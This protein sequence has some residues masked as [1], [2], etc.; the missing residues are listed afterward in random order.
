MQEMVFT[1]NFNVLNI[2][3]LTL[4]IKEYDENQ[5]PNI[6][7]GQLNVHFIWTCDRVFQFCKKSFGT[8][9]LVVWREFKWKDLFRE[10]INHLLADTSCFRKMFISI[11]AYRSGKTKLEVQDLLDIDIIDIDENITIWRKRM[12]FQSNPRWETLELK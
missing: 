12:T 7:K 6:Y 8:K 3:P 10:D 1:S 9:K 2:D 11:L 4:T 5:F